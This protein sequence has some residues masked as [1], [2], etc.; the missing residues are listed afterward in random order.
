MESNEMES[1]FLHFDEREIGS[2]NKAEIGN[3][4]EYYTK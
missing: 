1:V 2:G 4:V 3:R